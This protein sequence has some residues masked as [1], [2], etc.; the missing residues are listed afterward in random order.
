MICDDQVDILIARHSREVTF[1]ARA[2]GSVERT[3]RV[4]VIFRCRKLWW[5]PAAGFRE[6]SG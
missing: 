3:P 4:R 5:V 2:P 1:G 6:Q